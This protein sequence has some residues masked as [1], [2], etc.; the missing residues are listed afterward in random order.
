MITTIHDSIKEK[1]KA[2]LKRQ[3]EEQKRQ[4]KSGSSGS[5]RASGSSSSSSSSSS[6]ASTTSTDENFKFPDDV[7]FITSSD[8]L[9]HQDKVPVFDDFIW[10]Y[11]PDLNGWVKTPDSRKKLTHVAYTENETEKNNNIWLW[12]LG[13]VVVVGGGFLLFGGKKKKKRK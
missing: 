1:L 11:T 12:L 6:S 3:E 5:S 13:G 2:Q 8:Y 10:V 7:T 4:A 9:Q